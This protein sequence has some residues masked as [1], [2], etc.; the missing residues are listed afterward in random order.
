MTSFSSLDLK[1]KILVTIGIISLFIIIML[2]LIILLMNYTDLIP[3]LL[4]SDI[5]DINLDK[6]ND[7]INGPPSN[8]CDVRGACDISANITSVSEKIEEAYIPVEKKEKKISRTKSKKNLS[9]NTATVS[10]NAADA[11]IVKELPNNEEK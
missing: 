1:W 3:T 11:A 5:D 7:I 9:E 6:Y 4:F 2:V 8:N 10:E